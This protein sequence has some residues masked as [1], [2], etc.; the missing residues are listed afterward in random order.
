MNRNIYLDGTNLNSI[1]GF[2]VRRIDVEPIGIAN[3]E[4]DKGMADGGII[5]SQYLKPRNITVSGEIARTSLT[6]GQ[7]TLDNLNAILTGTNKVLG[8][9]YAGSYRTFTVTPLA[10]VENDWNGGYKKI[11]LLF[12]AYDPFGYAPNY[13]TASVTG[14]TGSEET[15]TI[16]WAGTYKALPIITVTLNSQTTSLVSNN[17]TLTV[18]ASVLIIPAVYA[19]DDVIVVDCEN[20]SVSINGAEVNYSGILP[21]ISS[22]VLDV[23][24]TDD[25]DTRNIDIEVQYKARYR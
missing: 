22:S 3:I 13:T 10:P 24:Y 21:T 11:Q 4:A 6:L 7:T 15:C 8:F 2:T 20:K 5:T 19:D 1:T 23:V 9:D 12:K 17:I 18:G 16:T 25:F 14:Q